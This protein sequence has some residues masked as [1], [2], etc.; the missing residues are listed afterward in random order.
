[1]RTQIGFTGLVVTDDVQMGAFSGLTD[2]ERAVRP[3]VAGADVVLT[4]RSAT[5]A[6][7]AIRAAVDAGTLSVEAVR[8][9]AA[10]VLAAK[11]RAG[12]HHSAGPDDA[13]WRRLTASGRPHPLA[14]A[15]AAQAITQVYA[16]PGMLPL[17]GRIA[18]V[19]I[20]NV[21]ATGTLGRAL[22]V[23]RDVLRPDMERRFDGTPLPS[24]IAALNALEAD[25][26]VVALHQRLVSGRGT[27]GLRDGQERLVAA[28]RGQ[29]RRLVF[30]SFGSPY[31]LSELSGADAALALYDS[32]LPSVRAAAAV[33]RGQAE[34]TGRLPVTLR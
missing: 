31:T 9:K 25:V 23:F 8:E 24:Q 11:A 17:Q 12:L 3:L 10:R 22:D 1:L 16:A 30:V 19:Q 14:D 34:A 7:A 6:L 29:G 33:L 18:L 4:P 27:A 2:A 26:V 5:A 21:R 20:A 28:L 32:T 15:V 13:L